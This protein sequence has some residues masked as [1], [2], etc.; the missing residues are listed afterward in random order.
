MAFNI[1]NE[2]TQKLAR[3][4]AKMTGEG[5]TQAITRA[6]RERLQRLQNRPAPALAEE[7]VKIGKDCAAHLKGPARS[8]DHAALLYDE[9]G[10]PR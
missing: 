4:L 7:L 6:L 1:K 5:I 10:L 8:V 3:D 2:E 9:K